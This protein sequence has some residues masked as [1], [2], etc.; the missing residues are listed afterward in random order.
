MNISNIAA[1]AEQLDTLGFK[2]SGYLLL[3][4]ICF[5]PENFS[6]FQKVEKGKEQL[7]FHLFF[8]KEADKKMYC[9]KYYDA[10]L[11]GKFTLSNT[12]INGIDINVLEEKMSAID[13]KSAFDFEVKKQWNVEDKSSWEKEQ[14]I[15][16]IVEELISLETSEVGKAAATDLKLK[17]WEGFSFQNLVGNINPLK[18]KAEVNQRFY[19]SEGQPGISVDEAYRFLQNRWMEKQIHAKRKLS[20]DSSDEE[21]NNGESS[22]TGKKLL[23]KK[24]KYKTRITK[25]DKAL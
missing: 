15:E 7:S 9:L 5:K 25:R 16:L 17:F 8:E 14:R 4:H 2:N 20:E 13:W 11:R 24:Q 3:K 21:G 10:V 1:L 18:T 19:F 22:S 12:P 23:Q 6:L